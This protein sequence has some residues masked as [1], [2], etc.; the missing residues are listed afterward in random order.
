EVLDNTHRPAEIKAWIKSARPWKNRKID[1]LSTFMTDFE[2][3]WRGLQ[4]VTRFDAFGS[5]HPP[6][7]DMDW[8]SLSIAGK[9]GVI[10]VVAALLWCGHAVKDDEGYNKERWSVAV[11]D[12]STVL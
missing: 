11:H 5:L 2:L 4:P 10:S 3:W 1:K 6:T 7:D 12:V 8:S 9:N